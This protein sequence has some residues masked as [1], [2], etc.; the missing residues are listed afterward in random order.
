MN[1]C[2]K[3]KLFSKQKNHPPKKKN[4]QN[5]LIDSLNF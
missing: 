2:E 3:K 5:K 1:N 4:D